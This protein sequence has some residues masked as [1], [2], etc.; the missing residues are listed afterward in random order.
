MKMTITEKVMELE[1]KGYVKHHTSYAA[2]YVSRK[3]DGYL[4]KYNGRFGRGYKL[5]QPCMHSTQY[6]YVTYYVKEG[7]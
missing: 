3:T 6:C 5:Y 4:V 7:C 2:G 1:K